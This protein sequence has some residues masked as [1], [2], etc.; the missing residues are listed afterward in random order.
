[1]HTDFGTLEG[2]WPQPQD[3]GMGDRGVH[4]ILSYLIM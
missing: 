2:H 3:F 1:M 4:E